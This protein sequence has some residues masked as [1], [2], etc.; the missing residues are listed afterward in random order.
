MRTWRAVFA[1][2]VAISLLLQRRRTKINN[3]RYRH[4]HFILIHQQPLCVAWR[5]HTSLGPNAFI[6]GTNPRN[7]L[8]WNV[9]QPVSR[10]TVTAVVCPTW[11]YF[12]QAEGFHTQL[13]ISVCHLRKISTTGAIFCF[14][15]G[16]MEPGS[17]CER[18]CGYLTMLDL[19]GPWTDHCQAV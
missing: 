15:L 18:Y 10:A 4:R 8:F 12:T 5:Q 16:F 7:V 13:L 2:I 14:V 9:A 19:V 11:R 17:V 6:Q 3:C 1:L